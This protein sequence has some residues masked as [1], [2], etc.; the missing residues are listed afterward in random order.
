MP[1]GQ[2]A[3]RASCCLTGV[4]AAKLETIFEMEL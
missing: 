3:G 1:V 2:L 4:A